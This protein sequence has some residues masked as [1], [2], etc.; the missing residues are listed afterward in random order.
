MSRRHC[1]KDW[2]KNLVPVREKINIAI[3]DMP[4][5]DEVRELLSGSCK[6]LVNW[7]EYVA[8]DI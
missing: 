3:Q 6:F 5:L 7:S 4:E 1:S 8:L 2:Q